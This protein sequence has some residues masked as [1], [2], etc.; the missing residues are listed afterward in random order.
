MKEKKIKCSKCFVTL[1]KLKKDN[2]CDYLV[3]IVN[4]DGDEDYI[5]PVC[6]GGW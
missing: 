6:Y 1:E 5:C 4:E 2:I 3:K